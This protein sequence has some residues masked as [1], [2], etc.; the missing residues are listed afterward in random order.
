MSTSTSTPRGKKLPP[1]AR[2]AQVIAGLAAAAALIGY[3]VNEHLESPAHRAQVALDEAR[4]MESAGK[5][6]DALAAYEGIVQQFSA[7][8]SAVQA[9]AGGVG[10]LSAKKIPAPCTAGSVEAARTAASPF[11]T[12]SEEARGG[13]AATEIAK[14]LDA[15][16]K[17][18]GEATPEARRASLQVLDLAA[19]AA[20][21]SSDASW[22]T[23]RRAAARR[24]FALDAAEKRPL[25]AI[26][27]LS[28]LADAESVAA[29]KKVIAGL[30][31]G[32][33]LR[34]EAAADIERWAQNA[35][36]AG[37]EAGANEAL[38]KLAAAR[39][40]HDASAKL[41]A[42]GDAQ[43]IEK[44][45]GEH[46]DDQ[47]LAI[48]VASRLRATGDGKG[49][50]AA[51]EKLGAP[52]RMTAAAQQLL[53]GLL[54]DAGELAKADEVLTGLCDERMP[55]FLDAQRDFNRAS[56]Q[57]A[58]RIADDLQSDVP[59]DLAK[60]VEGADE[61]KK[62][63]IVRAWIAKQVEADPRV[64]SARAVYRG[65]TAAVEASLSLGLVKLR[66]AAAAAGDERRRL[67]EQA[68]S[69]FVAIRDEAAGDASLHLGLGQALFR[70]GKNEE[71]EK[72]L[73]SVLDRNDPE[74]SMEV[75]R[76]YRE[77][78]LFSRARDVA[79]KVYEAA[80]GAGP[81][82]EA[83]DLLAHLATNVDEEEEWLR[84]SDQDDPGV[85]ASLDQVAGERLLREGK[86]K[87]AD[88]KFEKCVAFYD[89]SAGASAVAANNAATETIRRYLA[90]GDPAHLSRAV[91]YLDGAAKLDP[92]NALVLANLSGALL[93][94]GYVTVLSRWVDAKALSLDL[95]GA[96]AQI[97]A[98]MDGP[99][100]GEVLSALSKD[101]SVQRALE[102]SKRQ[103]AL[104]PQARD[105]YA[106]SVLWA[107]W[108]RDVK[109][110]E[111]LDE[112]IGQ[113]TMGG[114]D[115]ESDERRR[116]L[117][118]ERDAAAQS[119]AKAQ[120]AMARHRL[121]R[122]KSSPP[123]TQAAAE[124][125]LS[126][127]LVKAALFDR[128]AALLDEMAEAARKAHKAWP[129]GATRGDV[130]AAL[131]ASAFY[132]ALGTSPALKKAWDDERRKLG[133]LEIAY[134]ASTAPN[135]AEVT[136]A[137]RKDP[138]VAEAASVRRQAATDR[139]VLKDF[140]YARLAGDADLEKAA[141]KSF[142]RRDLELWLAID[143][144]LR[145]S[146]D[147]AKLSL[148][149]FRGRGELKR[150]E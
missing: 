86:L 145:P 57:A 133:P 14:R 78:G 65:G 39:A 47:E 66:H 115:A 113:L 35:R 100:A 24:A 136:A 125:A 16:A 101:A 106:L 117:A 116:W 17:E 147:K 82:R 8:P 56:Q 30:G 110:L 76:T 33:S 53:A 121:D 141:T 49:A 138:A 19:D 71:G 75:A 112:R 91:T 22:V 27:E 89:R 132:R 118:G 120:V 128:D 109:A 96:Q 93:H 13:G 9:A 130:S 3:A 127:A 29:G 77:L 62:T 25:L 98:M 108:S 11:V 142:D 51:I 111:G 73:Q 114:G 95:A 105:G 48:A 139:P 12:L 148:A 72:E 70:L 129:E 43:A 32:P 107:A 97:D 104:A 149:L 137:L 135:G 87:E 83:A 94:L 61:E 38:S 7:R 28:R 144:K 63:E 54:L 143:A 15:C 21:G 85:R 58:A 2:A 126:N 40:A 20:K 37:D 122:V 23:A 45:A 90:T 69:A 150:G 18:I 88:E 123:A 4:A 131:F 103:Q 6:D 36:A 34:V 81:K 26:S 46:P 44:A 5:D 41:L 84:R 55:P 52:G 68:E 50:R 146:D 1:R 74:L 60:Q 124:L 42:G 64:A 10:R 80:S 102:T 99:L 119:E 140:L 67:L 31:E 92:D 59:P 79:R 134:E